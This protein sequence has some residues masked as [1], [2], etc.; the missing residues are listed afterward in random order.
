MHGA[1]LDSHARPAT[2][3]PA[4]FGGSGAPSTTTSSAR[5]Q[6]APDQTVEQRAPLWPPRSHRPCSC[7][8][9]QTSS[10]LVG[11]DAERDEQR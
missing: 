5:L 1:A 7:I 10:A 9:E 4:P 2:A 6:S 11:A 3:P 8:G